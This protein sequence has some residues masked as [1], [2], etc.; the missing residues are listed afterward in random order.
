MPYRVDFVKDI[1][2]KYDRVELEEMVQVVLLCTQLNPCHIPK[3]YEVV[4]MLEGD[5]LAERWGA[6]QKVETPK[7]KGLK[8][9][10]KRYS[11]FIDEDSSLVLKAMELHV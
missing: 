4:R 10:T 6:S 8:I 2:P 5:G 1:K 11:D 7:Y 9:I 3:M